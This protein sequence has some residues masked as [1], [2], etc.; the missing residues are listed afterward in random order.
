MEEE[1]D[2]VELDGES[3]LN[4]TRCSDPNSPMDA[5]IAW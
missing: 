1:E 2:T 4:E 3:H 5:L